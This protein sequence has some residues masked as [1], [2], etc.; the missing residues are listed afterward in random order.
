MG[1]PL[2][3]Q[4]LSGLEAVA[5][6]GGVVARQAVEEGAVVAGL[7]IVRQRGH[8]GVAA[9]QGRIELIDLHLA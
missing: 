5:A 2:P 1:L 8:H 4:Q 6:G 3:L 9:L 7:R